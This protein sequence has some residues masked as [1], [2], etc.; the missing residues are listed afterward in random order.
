MGCAD[1][2]GVIR[3]VFSV[4]DPHLYSESIWKSPPSPSLSILRSV[5]SCDSAIYLCIYDLRPMSTPPPPPA[6]RTPPPSAPPLYV[7][8]S[9]V[10]RITKYFVAHKRDE[11]QAFGYDAR[12]HGPQPFPSLTT[13]LK[14]L[15]FKK[16]V[17]PSSRYNTYPLYG[18][19][20][21]CSQCRCRCHPKRS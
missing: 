9:P 13:F 17:I 8:S 16:G 5:T 1:V 14:F 19:L 7:G 2:H 18:H 6:P 21:C 3:V 12:I 4:G 20:H 11:F 10:S 15:T